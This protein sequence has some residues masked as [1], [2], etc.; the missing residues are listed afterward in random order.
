MTTA[1]RSSKAVPVSMSGPDLRGAGSGYAVLMLGTKRQVRARMQDL[2]HWRHLKPSDEASSGRII[3][4]V[5]ERRKATA[6]GAG[7]QTLRVQSDRGCL[8]WRGFAPAGGRQA[9][10]DLSGP[11]LARNRGRRLARQL[12]TAN[13]RAG[14]QSRAH[15][16]QAGAG[17]F[18]RAKSAKKQGVF[19]ALS[20]TDRARGWH[21]RSGRRRARPPQAH[22][23]P[24]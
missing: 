22:R 4:F 19:P 6:R 18:V 15:P 7:Q 21:R 23:R 17:R 12:G 5:A 24:R 1:R 11:N 13:A 8:G 9:R 2:G 3:G 14:A 20:Q 16:G 10:A